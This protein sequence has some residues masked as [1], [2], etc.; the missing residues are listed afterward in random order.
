MSEAPRKPT[1]YEAL[2]DKLGREPTNAEIKADVKRILEDGLIEL[3]S[4]GKLRHQRRH[5]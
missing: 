3:A 2:R 5:K 1:I 4:K